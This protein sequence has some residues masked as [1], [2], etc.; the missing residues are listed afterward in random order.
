LELCCVASEE[1][2]LSELEKNGGEK[3]GGGVKKEGDVVK[4]C[5]MVVKTGKIVVKRTT[6]PSLGP[7]DSPGLAELTQPGCVN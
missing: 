4:K 7:A 6:H 5:K 2:T 1:R 3:R